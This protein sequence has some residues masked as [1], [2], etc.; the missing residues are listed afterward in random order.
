MAG[1]SAPKGWLSHLE[2]FWRDRYDWL[3][4]S[5]YTLRPRYSPQ[6]V[7]SWE[8][9]NTWRYLCEDNIYPRST[10]VMDAV[11]VKD[12]EM[13]AIKRSSKSDYPYESD[14][15]Q[16][17]SSPTL[18]ADPRNRCCPILDVF[19]DPFDPDQRLI[20]M[21]LLRFYI[22][23]K[24]V[25]VG[26]AVEFFRQAFEGLQFIHEHHVA[27][28]DISRL[29][30]MMD[31][32]PILPDMF[33]PQQPSRTRDGKRFISPFTRTARP[34]KYYFTDFGLSRRYSPEVTNPLE[35]PIMGGDKT[36]PEFLKDPSIPRNPFHTDVY[37]IGNLI[38]RDF[39]EAYKNFAFMEPLIARMVQDAPDKRPT[40]DEVVVEFRGIMSNLSRCKLRERLVLRKD[41]RF[42]NILKDV[43][44]LSAHTVPY[45]F[46][47][48]SPIPTPKP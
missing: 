48:R 8:G 46:T 23:P 15:A 13:V 9:T 4:S 22:D 34:V 2:I 30:I 11:R 6:W 25:T 16:Y 29:N 5:G 44:H 39:L 26:E 21:P 1:E 3:Q 18:A 43:H 27:H 20:V 47:R 17:L 10:I 24:F 33:H 38:R 45:V 37:Y 14:I 7:P 31:S 42:M 40:M 12:G 28:R 32:K 35:Y 19:D 41:S 36:V